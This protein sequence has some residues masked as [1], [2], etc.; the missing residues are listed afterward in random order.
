MHYT[1]AEF[2]SRQ[3]DYL[4]FLSGLV[5]ILLAVGCVALR[6]RVASPSVGRGTRA[7]PWHLLGLFGLSFGLAK[8]TGLALAVSPSDAGDVAQLVLYW[9]AFV[10][11]L[12]FGR[13]GLASAGGP[14]VG[15]GWVAAWSAVAALG[16]AFGVSGVVAA[17]HYALALPAGA[18]GAWALFAESGSAGLRPGQRRPLKAAAAA[19][20]GLTAMI[21]VHPPVAL[22]APAGHLDADLMSSLLSAS[23]V[24]LRTILASIL[25]V[26]L[27]RFDRGA[28][29]GALRAG[30]RWAAVLF[31]LL[32]LILGAGWLGAE[33]TGRS[34]EAE[35]RRALVM[36][37]QTAA[38]ALNPAYVEN[39]TGT[40]SDTGTAG[41][42]RLREQL[43]QI[44]AAN[45]DSRSVYLMGNRDGAVVLL[46]DPQSPYQEIDTPPG[47]SYDDASPELRA[48]FETG[49]PIAEGPLP[50][51]WGV[52]VSG[53][54][55][56]RR[57]AD[58][59]VLGV[60]G[61][62]IDAGDWAIAIRA[63]RLRAILVALL[64]CVVVVAQSLSERR[65]REA[66][67]RLT[68]S[69][70]RYRS[71]VEGSPGSVALLDA[72]GCYVSLNAH[73]QRDMGYRED[74]LLGRPM[75]DLWPAAA[76]ARLADAI[77]AAA[78]GESV[79]CEAVYAGPDGRETAWHVAFSPAAGDE[80]AA[81]NVVAIAIDIT[82][83]ERARQELESRDRLT[84][85]LAR[86]THALLTVKDDDTAVQ[87]ALE[88]VGQAAGVDRA[89]VFQQHRDPAT[90]E[91]LASQRYEWSGPG[92]A[93]QIDNPDLQNV[94]YGRLF[95][96]WFQLMSAGES[97]K[98]PVSD[99]PETERVLLDPQSI[100]SLLVVPIM[101]EGECWGF[102]GF[103]DCRRRREW[104]DTEVSILRAAAS[105]IGG[106][107]QRRQTEQDLRE[108]KE[109]ADAASRAKSE[110]LAN[111]SHEIRTP[112]NA[113]I[114]MT[115]LLLDTLLTAEQRECAETIR[116]SGEILLSLIN[117][118]LDF[119]RIE[120]GKLELERQ[121][122]DVA[123]CIEET[124][125]LLGAR[126]AQKGLELAYEIAD[127]T[128]R[129]LM[130]DPTRLR[131]ILINLAGN[132]IKFTERGEIVIRVT[133]R[134]LDS[135]ADA[136]A[137]WPRD[138]EVQFAVR[139]TGIGIPADRIAHLFQAFTQV[140]ASTTRRYGGTGLGLA[141]SR[142]LAELMGGR[143]W[144]ESQAGQGSTFYFTIIAR[145]ADP[146][147]RAASAT[148]A[149]VDLSGRR[150]LVVDDNATNRHILV[151]QLEGWGMR[152][153]MADS[154][155]G[156][157][158]LLDRGAP[159]DL[160]ILDMHMPG[161]DGLM[162]AA[163]I[164]RRPRHQGLPLVMLTSMAEPISA[165][166][167]RDLG[168]AAHLTKPA[169]A[170]HLR[171]AMAEAVGQP[172]RAAAEVPRAG[173]PAVPARALR[174]LLAEDNV[175]NQKVAARILERNGYRADTAANGLE[176]LEAL[177]RQPYDVVL[178]DV[179]M[180]EMDGL[181]A[182]RRIRGDKSLS[183]QP[184]IV[185][186]TAGAFEE[187]RQKCLSAGMDRYISKPVRAAELAQTLAECQRA[188]AAVP[189]FV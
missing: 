7:M 25:L 109:A 4:A 163:E 136:R 108:A 157:L 53:L 16:L 86:G 143:M 103:D 116:V 11:L 146:A 167:A 67:A 93:A 170:I 65:S 184:F 124:L 75:V 76:R 165:A 82:D 148:A 23:I 42:Q 187:D 38:A 172:S 171:R 177:R 45:A 130:G 105:G 145:M 133:S 139:D 74:E 46:V 72:R 92:V 19:L 58:G 21:A 97:V 15:P 22:S 90:G 9:T 186:M 39:L 164:R 113:V 114:G 176:V 31:G 69:E 2:I 8:W 51:E 30:S 159:C 135:A 71:V 24:A 120:S 89:Y 44:R 12:E 73:G 183:R 106:A 153:T 134:T 115:G 56:V 88:I 181:E 118:I 59:A 78:R 98:G 111:M 26:C 87:Q 62:D 66:A 101:V 33:W 152:V 107:V 32:A 94:P 137:P 29:Y 17:T 91:L 3:A 85:G 182:T 166:A 121:P 131:Q 174:I 36:R 179:Q 151:H 55:P 47:E 112:M 49:A 79:S 168:I 162:L 102:V 117:D 142:R 119:S 95:P 127:D 70:E 180:P 150:V 125:D 61:I 147:E 99:F 10:S 169:K 27:W 81:R 129:A 57:L 173:M 84:A 189:A 132:A 50:D 35:M 104:S 14:R 144:V 158:E 37:A 40:P 149:G 60:L 188:S 18:W 48:M 175:V 68:S 154:G 160:A 123:V 155:A 6:Q 178:M 20:L 138:R 41:Y 54:A 185:A 63:Q 83:T 161:M 34:A 1:M 122:F 96:R 52:W 156:A 28:P 100:V 13:R 141:I 43:M 110:F 5:F 64:V 128:P 80:P 140:D 77:A 126:A